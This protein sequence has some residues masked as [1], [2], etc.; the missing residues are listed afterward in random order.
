VS[1]DAAV[2]AQC[3]GR[4]GLADPLPD[5]CLG[6]IDTDRPHQTDTPHVVPAGHVQF[7]SA[8]VSVPIVARTAHVVLFEDAYKFGLVDGVDLQLLMKHA[9]YVPSTARLAPP[10]PLQ[11]RGKISVA[12]ENGWAPA[13]TLVPWLVVPM[14]RSQ[15]L[16]AG[17]FVFWGW[18]LP[19]GLE[20][21][22]NT[23]I[24][25]SGPPKQAA[26]LLLASALTWTIVGNL[27]V[28]ADI[29]AV[30][31]DVS[32]GSGVLWAFTRDVQVDAGTYLGVR[33]DVPAATPFVG[34]SF[35][36]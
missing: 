1:G 33:G 20:L 23:G 10:G 36:R 6:V 19:F 7:E 30:A 27:R 9:E 31:Y 4:H 26:A 21:E 28:F 18:E 24:F 22:V 34:L 35:R 8:L 25:F 17:P 14:D 32:F 12:T 5:A 29:Y 3:E 16:R 13:I 15:A 11:V 2:H